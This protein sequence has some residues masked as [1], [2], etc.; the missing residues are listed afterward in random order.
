MSIDKFTNDPEY[1][2][3]VT[4]RDGSGLSKSI[5]PQHIDGSSNPIPYYEVSVKDKPGHASDTTITH[6]GPGAGVSTGIGKS[7]DMQGFVSTT[8]NK[9]MIDNTFGSD[10]IVLQHHSGATIMIDADGSIHMISSGKKGIGMVS[11]K[12]DGTVFAKNHLILKAD[13]KMTI[14][15]DGDLDIN[16][17]GAFSLHVKGDMHTYVEGSIEE[18]TDGAKITEVVKDMS[19][20]VGGDNRI[21]VAGNMHTQV[22]G[23]KEIDVGKDT[24]IR[25]DKNTLIAT[26]E[27]MKIMSIGDMSH[28]TKAKFTTKSDDDMT[29]E[30]KANYAVKIDGDATF[31][32]KGTNTLKSDG[33]LSINT[34]GTMIAKA[35]GATSID[36]QANFDLKVTG[37]TKLSSTGNFHIDTDGDLVTKSDGAT[38]IETQGTFDAKASDDMKLSSGGI[39]SIQSTGVAD[40]RS[41]STDIDAGDP[42]PSTP[43]TPAPSEP[44]VP[45]PADDTSEVNKAPK[46]Q[47]PPAETIVDNMTTVREAPDFL[48]NAKRMSKGEFSLYKNEGNTPNPK[49]EAAASP[50]Q[51]AGAP[52]EITEGES[53]DPQAMGT[54][55]KSANV[56]NN[57]TAEQNPLPMPSS[58]Y[59]TNEKISKHVTVGQILGLRSTPVG[60]QKDVISE[61]MHVAWNI[62]DPL[63][64]KYGGRIQI[65]SWYRSNSGNHAKGGAVDL[66]CSNKNDVQTTSEIAAFVR[67][68]LPY[69]KILLEKNDSPG[70]HVHVEAAKV[71]NSG[72]GTVLTCADPKCQSSVSGIQLQYA[73]AALQGRSNA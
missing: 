25:S 51:G 7:T 57:G 47:Y 18:F 36:T 49:A 10:T 44:T 53:A 35:I 63:I 34:Q 54:Y 32:N 17:G 62:I 20:T 70:I 29:H 71:G 69:S 46:A 3:K 64:E 12:G 26:Q 55:D 56:S 23:Q 27:T 30:T 67:D 42:S 28:D 59:N 48:K 52:P 43:A 60:E 13:G 14:E 8:G 9:V 24:F 39:M 15:T 1:V 58:I 11:P 5:A 66:R 65:T 21:T 33:D 37:D 50:N 31:D 72:G 19:H 16:V 73:V 4:N 2:K 41:A 38:S 61:A 45:D 22:T 6:T 68:N 40:F